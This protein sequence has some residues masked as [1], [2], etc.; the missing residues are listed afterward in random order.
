M[1]DRDNAKRFLERRIS[2]HELGA[3]NGD[4]MD[5]DVVA[6]SMLVLSIDARLES[7][8]DKMYGESPPASGERGAGDEFG[9]LFSALWQSLLKN[10]AALAA[11]ISAALA[12][13]A[14]Q[15]VQFFE[16]R[17]FFGLS[18]IDGVMLFLAFT[19]F[20]VAMLVMI[21]RFSLKR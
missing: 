1:I 13:F 20:I 11:A 19:L 6:L 8:I 12:F 5:P 21:F 14:S 10:K 18:G 9:V 3:P 4:N 2:E 17:Q 16:V 15:T 7:L